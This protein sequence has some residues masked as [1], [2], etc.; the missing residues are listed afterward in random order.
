MADDYADLFKSQSGLYI[1][2]PLSV[3]KKDYVCIETLDYPMQGH[4]S[5]AFWVAGDG[6]RTFLYFTTGLAEVVPNRSFKVKKVFGAVSTMVVG[7]RVKYMV[8][9]DSPWEDLGPVEAGSRLPEDLSVDSV[10][11]SYMKTPVEEEEQL[12]D[13]LKSNF[14]G[15]GGKF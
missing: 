8:E 15:D 3:L 4:R 2:L 6:E 7:G 13:A 12:K 11:R 1:W 10:R 14:W 5:Y 9:E